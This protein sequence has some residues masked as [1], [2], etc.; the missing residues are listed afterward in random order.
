MV[1][2]ESLQVHDTQISLVHLPRLFEACQKIEK[3]SFSLAEKNVDALFQE[4]YWMKTG[5][6]KVQDL[7]IIAFNLENNFLSTDFWSTLFG[8]LK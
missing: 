4:N 1:N 2:L 6:G 3:F 5:F 8:V 7:K